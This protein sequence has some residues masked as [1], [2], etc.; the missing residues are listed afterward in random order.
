MGYILSRR[1]FLA[2]LTSATALPLLSGC[3]IDVA[4]NPL[5]PADTNALK[6]LDSVADAL[7]NLQPEGA[8]SLGIDTGARAVLRSQLSDLSREGRQRLAAQIR[9]DLQRVNN[10]NTAGLSYRVRTSVE[11]VRTATNAEIH[12]DV[13]TRHAV[14]RVCCRNR[15]QRARHVHCRQWK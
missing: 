1:D 10:F 5:A 12:T 6:L 4:G 9:T 14:F 11:V 7:L 2:A 8:T 15:V 13:R 3:G